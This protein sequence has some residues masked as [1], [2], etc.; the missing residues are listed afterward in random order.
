M[1]SSLCHKEK[2]SIFSESEKQF[3]PLHVAS[4]LGYNV[5]TGENQAEEIG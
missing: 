3:S 5:V 2:H 4:R 1:V